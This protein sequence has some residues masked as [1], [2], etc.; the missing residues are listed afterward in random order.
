MPA[1]PT[2]PLAPYRCSPLWIHLLHAPLQHSSAKWLF[3]P[4]QRLHQ[5]FGPHSS[6]PDTPQKHKAYLIIGFTYLPQ[7][8]FSFQF[9]HAKWKSTLRKYMTCPHSYSNQIPEN[10]ALNPLLNPISNPS[11][12]SD[13]GLLWSE[14][15]FYCN[16][17][18]SMLLSKVMIWGSHWEVIGSG[19]GNVQVRD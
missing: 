15:E 5:P 4:S 1:L 12:H 9:T 17:L 18:W 19:A 10:L 7:K 3:D 16:S 2:A 8:Y 13:D 11:T 6:S 14:Y